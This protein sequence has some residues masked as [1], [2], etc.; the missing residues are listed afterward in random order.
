MFHKDATAAAVVDSTAAPEVDDEDVVRW[1]E[2]PGPNSRMAM[3][4]SA[5]TTV[6]VDAAMMAAMTRERVD[7]MVDY[8]Y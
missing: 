7:L 8:Y 6:D 2:P 1:I 4:V 3:V 5:R